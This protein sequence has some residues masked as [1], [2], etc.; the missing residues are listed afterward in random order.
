MYFVHKTKANNTILL[1]CYLLLILI[2]TLC[3]LATTNCTTTEKFT[4]EPTSRSRPQVPELVPVPVPASSMALASQEQQRQLHRQDASSGGDQLAVVGGNQL[5]LSTNQKSI[6]TQQAD[7][8]ANAQSPL[9]SRTRVATEPVAA[10]AAAATQDASVASGKE[11]GVNSNCNNGNDGEGDDGCAEQQADRSRPDLS[12]SK[13]NSNSNSLPS[14]DLNELKHDN[15]HK[16]MSEH[17]LRRTFYV[18]SHDQVPEYQILKL[19]VQSDGSHL[20]SPISDLGELT[21]SATAS[22][23]TTSARTA[24]SAASEQDDIT[25]KTT[26][27]AHKHRTL[28]SNAQATTSTSTSPTTTITNNKLDPQHLERSSPT[29]SDAPAVDQN[30]SYDYSRG[31]LASDEHAH[32]LSLQD[33]RDDDQS[34][35]ETNKTSEPLSGG[36][37]QD[38]I[39]RTN[40]NKRSAEATTATKTTTTNSDTRSNAKSNAQF[41]DAKHEQQQQQPQAINSNDKLIV[42]NLSTFG[43]DF[44]LRLKRNADF[45]QRIKDMKMFLAE[46]TGNGQLRYTEIK[47]PHS[48]QR[49]KQ[50]RIK[51][52]N[53][54]CLIVFFSF[55]SSSSCFVPMR[56]GPIAIWP[57][58]A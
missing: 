9:E 53:Q 55:S 31:E 44:N 20:I 26:T 18:D 7:A 57:P 58:V 32:E 35:D 19:T 47:S 49:H 4:I 39:A 22:V 17:D 25:T 16:L 33:H 8:N 45:Q 30:D 28:P 52:P 11:K 15:V 2:A 10:A 36:A 24:A 34:L 5:V 21:A 48:Q 12:A 13:S 37:N 29:L 40:R 6:D 3:C 14:I 50:V 41:R 46:S 38:Q 43:R 51:S 23:A 1:I 42:M 27:T 56:I 54:V